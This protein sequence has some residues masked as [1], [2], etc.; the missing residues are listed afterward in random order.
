MKRPRTQ[1]VT[2]RK[3]NHYCSRCRRSLADAQHSAKLIE[4]TCPGGRV[5]LQVGA[6]GSLQDG[7]LPWKLP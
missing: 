5:A 3:K 6:H 7:E 2:G 4:N 1:K